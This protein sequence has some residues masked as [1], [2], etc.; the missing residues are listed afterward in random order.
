MLSRCDLP[1]FCYLCG[2]C[3][4]ALNPVKSLIYGVLVYTKKPS[5]ILGSGLFVAKAFEKLSRDSLAILTLLS[6]AFWDFVVHE[7]GATLVTL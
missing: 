5:F 4:L 2:T 6:S 1:P 3:L 7:V